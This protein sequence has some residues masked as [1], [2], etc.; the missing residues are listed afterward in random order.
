MMTLKLNKIL[1]DS[2]KMVYP[3]DLDYVLCHDEGK[4]QNK[5]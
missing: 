2:K 4:R 5:S 3:R 1:N